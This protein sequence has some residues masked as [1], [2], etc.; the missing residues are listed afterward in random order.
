MQRKMHHGCIFSRVFPDHAIWAA[1]I[2]NDQVAEWRIYENTAEN[3]R[4]FNLL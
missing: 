2:E 3:R 1:L 4:K